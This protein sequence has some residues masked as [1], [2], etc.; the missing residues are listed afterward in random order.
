VDG[1]YQIF[2]VASSGAG[3]AVQVTSDP[4]HKTQPSFSPDGRTLAFTVW[5][6]EDRF[7]LLDP[8][9]R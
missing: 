3:A 1:V 4:S 6:Y 8:P 9:A 7:V 2:R 5:R